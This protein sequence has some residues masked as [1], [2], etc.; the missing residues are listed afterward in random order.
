MAVRMAQVTIDVTDVDTMAR[1]WSAALGYAADQGDDGCARLYPPV[2]TTAPT[3]W[4][5]ASGTPHPGKNRLHL[6]LVAD[7]GRAAVAAEVRRLTDLG[8]RPADV[9][10]RGDEPFVVLADPEGNEF[11]VLHHEP[12]RP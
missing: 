1:F 3:I 12:R 5:Q 11:C 10:Q 9:G 4:L 6:D 8:A 7:G 2:G